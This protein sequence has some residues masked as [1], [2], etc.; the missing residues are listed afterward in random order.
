MKKLALVFASLCLAAAPV[1]ACPH[2]SA[3]STDNAPRT[4]E[5][6]KEKEQPKAKETDKA[7]STKDG[8]K[9]AKP[10]EKK[11]DKVSSR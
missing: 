8:D 7:K 9:T 6:A 4:A 2:D 5:K 11:A 10:A 1:L 3:E